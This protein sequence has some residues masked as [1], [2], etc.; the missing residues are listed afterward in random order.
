MKKTGKRRM[1]SLKG[2]IIGDSILLSV[3]SFEK[4]IKE[5]NLH[6]RGFEIKITKGKT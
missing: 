3:K 4:F 5:I 1:A 2:S 6:I